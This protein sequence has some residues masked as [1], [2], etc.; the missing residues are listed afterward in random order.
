M[1]KVMDELHDDHVN[2]TRL[3]DFLEAEVQE[4][5]ESE[6]INLKL[7]RDVMHYMTHYPDMFHHRK[8]DL[9]FEKLLERDTAAKPVIEDLIQEHEILRQKGNRFLEALENAISGS[10]SSE[11]ILRV[12]AKDYVSNLRNHM[13][14]EEGQVFPLAKILLTNTDWKAIAVR[15]KEQE[16]PLF[17]KVVDDTYSTLNAE[18]RIREEQV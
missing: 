6:S 13:N 9:V 7:M 16:D 11:E 4:A 18:I 14:K 3:L 10:A 8:E 1:S 2:V 17:G 15:V 5:R 12:L